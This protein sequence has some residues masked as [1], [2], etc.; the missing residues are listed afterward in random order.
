[1]DTLAKIREDE[2]KGFRDLY[3]FKR[4]FNVFSVVNLFLNVP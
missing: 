4:K 3:I 1:M 2:G